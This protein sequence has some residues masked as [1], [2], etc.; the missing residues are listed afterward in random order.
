ML[1]VMETQDSQDDF[2]PPKRL[3]EIVF[4]SFWIAVLF[5]IA[6][7]V[8]GIVIGVAA[9]GELGGVTVAFVVLCLLWAG[10]AWRAHR[11]EAYR[12]QDPRLHRDRER[13]GY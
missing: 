4:D 7:Y 11:N 6:F 12:M 9:P 2:K 13:R 8:F 10:H 3:V 1:G 5:A